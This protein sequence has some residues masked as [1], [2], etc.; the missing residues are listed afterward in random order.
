MNET[1]IYYAHHQWKYGT[2]VE[3]YE[4][5]LIERYFPHATIFNPSVD[6]DIN[7]RTEEEIMETCLDTVRNSD[8]F[9]FSSMDG[10]VGK[11]VY[12]ELLE[13]QN[14]GK[15]ILYIS[16]NRLTTEYRSYSAPEYGTDRLYAELYSNN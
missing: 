14:H 16:R 6:L 10:M 13:A 11:G 12:T 1:T 3:K 7:G 15:L 9:I 4:L 2:M 5:H 8:I